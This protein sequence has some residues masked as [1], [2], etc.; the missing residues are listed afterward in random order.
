MKEYISTLFSYVSAISIKR[1]VSSIVYVPGKRDLSTPPS[2]M[3]PHRNL[4]LTP[5]D[6]ITFYIV[7]YLGHATLVV[8]V[9]VSTLNLQAKARSG[10]ITH[11]I[12]HCAHTCIFAI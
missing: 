3:S 1:I 6:Q 8:V 11:N 12:P 4:R 9:L 7:D 5:K 10:H 2:G